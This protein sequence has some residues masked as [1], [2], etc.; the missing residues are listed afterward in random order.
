MSRQ[1]DQGGTQVQRIQLRHMYHHCEV[2]PACVAT[3]R[4]S[5]G[6]G[7]HAGPATDSARRSCAATAT[8]FQ[9]SQAL[10]EATG[11]VQ[12]SMRLPGLHRTVLQRAPPRP[13]SARRRHDLSFVTLV[14]GTAVL[15]YSQPA[16]ARAALSLPLGSLVSQESRFQ[17][18]ALPELGGPSPSWGSCT[19]TGVQDT[20]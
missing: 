2:S 19:P 3:A 20:P 9:E 6:A 8:A 13:T 17:K 14:Q 10:G 18:P 16:P 11:P 4:R 15:V 12:P 7:G 5:S 1:D